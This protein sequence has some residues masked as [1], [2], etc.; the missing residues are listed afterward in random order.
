M[1][2]LFKRLAPAVATGARLPAIAQH[3]THAAEGTRSAQPVQG[4]GVQGGEP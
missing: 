1:N 2:K 3:N 4:H